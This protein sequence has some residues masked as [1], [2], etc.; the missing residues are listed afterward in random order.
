MLGDEPKSKKRLA[1]LVCL[2]VIGMLLIIAAKFLSDWNKQRRVIESRAQGMAAY[3]KGDYAGA[4]NPLS[5]ALANERNDLEL[6]LA[7]AETRIR[8]T[9][10]N[11][12]H[13][14]AAENLYQFA[15]SLDPDN[16][17]ALNALFSIYVVTNQ[18]SNA[19]RTA[20]KLPESDPE[21]HKKRTIA[22]IRI[23]ENE[24]ALASISRV[25][26]LDPGSHF[27]P[28]REYKVR[29]VGLG[30]SPDEILSVFEEH[31]ENHPGNP[32]VEL[33]CI[34]TMGSCLLYTSPSPRDRTRSRMPSSA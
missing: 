21:S 10:E 6:A 18:P 17:Q 19:L 30:Q 15:L 4:L 16:E 20:K 25:R 31:R 3:E 14:V 1:L 7:F 11:G 12:R 8:N 34:E 24:E 13:L 9:D 33:V 23:G 22:H 2:I 28:I 5:F 27:W 32:A 29:D 26:E